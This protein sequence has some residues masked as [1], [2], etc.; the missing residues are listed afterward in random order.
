[1]PREINLRAE[2]GEPE[3]VLEQ[4]RTR[5]GLLQPTGIVPGYRLPI[6]EEAFRQQ[7]IDPLHINPRFDER[8]FQ[9]GLVAAR[10]T[11]DQGGLGMFMIQVPRT[12]NHSFSVSEAFL[13]AS[14][15][16]SVHR[17][18][19]KNGGILPLFIVS[20]GEAYTHRE[21]NNAQ[22]YRIEDEDYDG[23]EKAVEEGRKLG[24]LT[25]LLKRE[26]IQEEI[27]RLVHELKAGQMPTRAVKL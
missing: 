22:K 13:H 19:F 14:T 25:V 11:A 1:M 4:F 7:G 9:R 20:E 5:G 26:S 18:T 6:Y 17:S 3:E 10:F 2:F 27:H 21:D 24:A 23:T 8:K 16:L 12:S 15:N